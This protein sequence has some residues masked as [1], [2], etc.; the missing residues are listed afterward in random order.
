MKR[1][2]TLLLI[3][4]SLT[5]AVAEDKSAAND[6]TSTSQ[7][8]TQNLKKTKEVTPPDNKGGSWSKLKDIF[9]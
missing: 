7:I 9:M 6:S 2:L 8:S 5:F 1:L 4:C 3:F